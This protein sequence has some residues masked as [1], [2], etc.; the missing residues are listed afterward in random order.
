MALAP[1]SKT[2]STATRA[3]TE[4]LLEPSKFLVRTYTR[5]GNVSWLMEKCAFE[6]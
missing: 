4:V 6:D 1:Q 2:N 3:F 5:P